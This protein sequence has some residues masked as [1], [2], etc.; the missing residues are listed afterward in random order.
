MVLFN[1]RKYMKLRRSPQGAPAHLADAVVTLASE[2]V[3]YTGSAI[4]PSVT[5][6]Y[7]GETLEVNTDYTLAYFDNTEIGAATVVVTGKGNYT[8]QVIKTFQI[9]AASGAWLFDLDDFPSTVEFSQ[10][11]G[12][13]YAYYH[14]ICPSRDESKLLIAR[15]SGGYVA[16]GTWRDFDPSTYENTGVTDSGLNAGRVLYTPDGTHYLMSGFG[17]QTI[18]I[19]EGSAAYDVTTISSSYSSLVNVG[20]SIYGGSIS[21]DGRHLLL[22]FP[23]YLYSYDL[24]TPFDLSTK[25]N[26]KYSN[27]GVGG[28]LFVN[29]NNGTQVL[30]I[31]N[32]N[33]NNPTVRMYTL[34]NPWDASSVVATK[35]A[36]PTIKIGSSTYPSKGFL[37]GVAVNNAGNKIMFMGSAL[38][39]SG[40]PVPA[41]N[42]SYA[43][44]VDFSS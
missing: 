38:D 24:S 31:N 37:R 9:V 30:Q 36:T 4:Y 35:S 18:R 26:E 15:G 42:M 16:V 44:I 40:S 17:D 25:G 2:T 29:Q 3:T 6:T 39:M 5:V 43:A 10:F 12:S 11:G 34:E 19:H 27:V 41:S 7:D 32:G 33:D 1:R 14:Q 21:Q 8:G 20:Y 13:S 23:G 28:A 22:S